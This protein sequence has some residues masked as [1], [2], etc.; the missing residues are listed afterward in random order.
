[1]AG[2]AIKGKRGFQETPEE[3]LLV[4]VCQSCG[5]TLLVPPGTVNKN[6]YCSNECKGKGMVGKPGRR[7]KI[8]KE[9]Y[10]KVP[11]ALT[12]CNEYSYYTPSKYK[13]LIKN[14][15]E[16]GKDLKLYCCYE[17]SSKAK[18]ITFKEEVEIKIEK[19][20]EKEVKVKIWGLGNS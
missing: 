2:I 20:K 3:K 15:I 16:A 19:E 9:N 5:C 4:F 1:M 13:R 11:C 14:S 12:G 6:K 17:H 10:V 18:T 8:P 7:K